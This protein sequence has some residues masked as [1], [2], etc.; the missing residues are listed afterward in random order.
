MRESTIGF[1][2]SVV[3]GVAGQIVDA[4]KSGAIKRF[5]LI[6]GSKGIVVPLVQMNALMGLFSD[7]NMDIMSQIRKAASGRP[8]LAAS[9]WP[10]TGIGRL[11]L[12]GSR[13]SCSACHSRH[14]FSP[15]RAR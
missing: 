14:D 10:N 13:G 5:Y 3:L 7:A 6:A 9:S 4:V 11:N 2:H 12:D 1:H 8:I 15:R